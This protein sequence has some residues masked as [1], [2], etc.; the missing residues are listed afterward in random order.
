MLTIELTNSRDGVEIHEDQA[1]L[2]LLAQ[3]LTDLAERSPP[4]HVRTMT[5]DWGGSGLNN[6][7]QGLTS[8]LIHQLC[9]WSAR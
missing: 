1:G 9:L 5:S 3:T 6:Q 7:R 4:D 8:E 2:L